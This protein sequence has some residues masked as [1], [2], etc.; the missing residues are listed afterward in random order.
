MLKRL[1]ILLSTIRRV[2]NEKVK[3]KAISKYSKNII[4]CNAYGVFGVELRSLHGVYSDLNAS[5]WGFL[6]F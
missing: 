3:Q 6:N 1:N 4:I 5:D 2:F